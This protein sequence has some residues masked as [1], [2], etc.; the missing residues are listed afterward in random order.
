M[1]SNIDYVRSFT[2]TNAAKDLDLL[3]TALSPNQ[4]RYIYAVSYGTQL[5]LRLMQVNNSHVT[6]LILDSL[7]PLQNDA[8]Y[9][10]SMRSQ[11]VNDIGLQILERCTSQESCNQNHPDLKAVLKKLVAG[12]KLASDYTSDLPDV[13]LSILLGNMLDVPAAR[14]KLPKLISEL[15]QGNTAELMNAVSAVEHYYKKFNPG[16]QNFGSSIPLVQVISAS[17]NTMRPNLSAETIQTESSSLLFTSPL[18]THLANNSM[19]TYPPDSYY[20]QIPQML[21]TTIVLHGNLDPKTHY[22]AALEHV[23]KLEKVGPI[24]LIE[25]A[26]A[27]HFTA[28]S[29]KKCFKTILSNFFDSQGSHSQSCKDESVLLKF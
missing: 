7:V 28:I 11:V 6:G 13:P 23:K 1:Y 4:A 25:I 19:P 5:A 17:E 22:F 9:G 8:E 3:L 15:S 10:L 12:N 16:Y 20:A 14:G 27:P 2:I 24:S 21:P 18:P 26:D 29:A